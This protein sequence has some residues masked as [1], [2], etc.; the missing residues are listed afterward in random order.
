MKEKWIKPWR[1]AAFIAS[2]GALAMLL[3]LAFAIT[4]AAFK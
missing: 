3:V 4:L 1:E 2:A